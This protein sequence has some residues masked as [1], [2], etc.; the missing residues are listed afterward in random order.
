[1]CLF[2][3]YEWGVMKLSR[4]LLLT[5][6]AGAVGGYFAEPY[7]RPYIFAEKAKP[8]VAKKPEVKD[9][10]KKVEPVVKKDDTDIFDVGKV[11]DG[12]ASEEDAGNF[13]DSAEDMTEEDD[14]DD[15][16]VKKFK[17]FLGEGGAGQPVQEPFYKAKE[18]SAWRNPQALERR[19][20]ARMRSRLKGMDA[21]SVTD[22][23]KDP[24]N[25]LMISQW[26][27]LHRSDLKEL[28][29]L[30][31][32]AE[33]CRDLTPLLN[34]LQWVSAF[35]YDS[36]LEKPEVA[37]AMLRHFRQVD[38]RMDFD[39]LKDGDGVQ[40]G[41]KKRVAG[42]IAIQFTRN[43][44]YGEEKELTQKEILELKE[45]GII[46]PKVKGRAKKD[47]YRLARE[48]Y[49]FFAESIDQSLLHG[50]FYKM[51]TWLIH[52][53][54][55]WKGN[56][57]FG[58]ANTMRWLR[59]NVS[60][61]A[62]TY[63]GM[64][65]QVPYLPTN[66]F[67]DSIFSSYY[68]QPFEVLY[69]DNFAKMTRDVG[70]VCGGLSHFGTSSACANGVPAI[71][72]GEPGHCAYAVFVDG[73]WHP[74]NSIGE[75]HHPHWKHWGEFGRWSALEMQAAMYQ[76]GQ[77]T[78]DAQM[79]CSLASML[80]K[81]RNPVN[82]LKL[83]EMAVGMQP[84]YSPVIGLYIDTATASLR[85]QP[86]KWLGV[87]Q[88][89][90]EA[91]AP[92]HPEMCAKFLTEKIYPAM[93]PS[94]R[95]D[96]QKMQAFSDYFNNLNEDEESYWDIEEILNMQYGALGK[97][98]V[99]KLD[100]LKLVIDTA[101]QKTEFSHAITW[102]LRTATLEHKRLGERTLA[103]I[104]EAA[105]TSPDKELVDAAVIRAGEELGDLE[106]VHKYSAPYLDRKVQ[107]PAFDK[108]EGNLIS[109]QGYIVLGK[110]HPEQRSITQHQAALS[111]NGGFI[112]S[113]SGK[114]QPMTL[115]LPKAATLGTVIIIPKGGC[116]EYRV[117][118]IEISMDGKSWRTLSMLP[119]GAD[120]PFVRLNFK[121]NNPKARYIRVDSGENQTLGIQFNAF[122]VYDNKKA[123]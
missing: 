40:A 37:L 20:A 122:L 113:D 90:C 14:S 7:L 89:V 59:D 97:A 119:E 41:L 38:E 48:R 109:P 94:M 4:A 80:S 112:H 9:E 42:A 23:L 13:A 87:N 1:M 32:D 83:Y 62:A 53:V 123:K 26:E 96:K 15:A 60:A 99:R 28:A 116:K 82:G 21:D 111:E 67:G 71:T 8:D 45:A 74:C 100:F 17:N 22:F 115:V 27:L 11:D 114:H 95:G 69:P 121:R 5:L 18:D 54:V 46:L 47:P 79:V 81:H 52:Y 58:T 56:S 44:W 49:L 70:A 105:K 16:T 78:R 88:F 68:Y 43:G 85:R 64:A 98:Q 34:D 24:E 120:Q 65:Y 36:E 84:L 19:L 75:E 31:R 30:L 66:I 25:R 35:V 63:K 50:G 2:F 3:C 12:L 106:L 117:W 57:P 55:G 103:L 73:K 39:V 102:A 118:K 92:K 104:D 101:S 6:I 61:P 77:R 86:R 72:M 29:A 91:V 110:T 93:L 108:P 10:P 33:T 76:D 107:L 51:P